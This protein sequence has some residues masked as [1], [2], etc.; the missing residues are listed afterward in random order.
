MLQLQSDFDTE[1]AALNSKIN[2]LTVTNERLQKQN[3]EKDCTIHQLNTT[4]PQVCFDYIL[5]KKYLKHFY[6]FY[7]VEIFKGSNYFCLSLFNLI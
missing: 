5:V 6:F 4:I 2:E 1:K 7:K 3:D